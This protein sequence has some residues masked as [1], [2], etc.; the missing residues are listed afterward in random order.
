M[1]L[2]SGA[3]HSHKD[4]VDF[5]QWTSADYRALFDAVPDAVVIAS[6]SGEIVMTNVQVETLFGYE[7]LQLVG[8]GISFLVPER[9]R[10]QHAIHTGNFLNHPCKREMG[11]GLELCALRSNGTEF[12]AEISL[13][14]L[15]IGTAMFVVSTIRD[16]SER[17][18]ANEKIRLQHQQLNQLT[19]ELAASHHELEAFSYSIAHDLRA[20]LRQIEGFSKILLED[21]PHSLPTDL[22]ECVKHI[23]QGALHMSRLVDGLLELSCLARRPVERQATD[24]N[25]L[26][27]EVIDEIRPELRTRDVRWKVRPLSNVQCDPI[28]TKQVFTNL[29][30][31]A[32]KFTRP[33]SRAI[34]EIEESF[35]D[36]HPVFCIRDNGVGFNMQYADKLFVV[37]QR[38]HLQEE[39]EGLGIGLA[40][41]QRIVRKHGGN[42]WAEAEPEHGAAFFF[43]LSPGT[44][45]AF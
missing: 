37:F 39:F 16:S 31:N 34:I 8:K 32:V 35:K 2:N 17:R 38:L 1:N 41:V 27:R 9:Y 18:R 25:R 3:I 15:A 11:V 21:S 26:V 33:R 6:S 29:L 12:P 22:P 24:M 28:L 4:C 43:T 19:N 10:E 30:S 7:R 42:I 40:T 45:G 14:P 36:G 20:P 13:S 5:S 23:R 44:E